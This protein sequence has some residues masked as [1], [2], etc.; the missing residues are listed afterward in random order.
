MVVGD[1][2]VLEGDV[3]VRA[4]QHAPPGGVEVVERADAVE[5]A[6]AGRVLGY[7]RS[8]TNATSSASRFE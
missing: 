5:V 1:A 6:H 4:Q 2:P 7:S 8:P 3:E